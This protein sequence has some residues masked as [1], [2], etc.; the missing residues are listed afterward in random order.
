MVFL[1]F[2]W[3]MSDL[4]FFSIAFWNGFESVFVSDLFLSRT[5]EC[6]NALLARSK[7]LPKLPGG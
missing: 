4:G 6:G 2:V 1:V 5:A 7:T 3:I